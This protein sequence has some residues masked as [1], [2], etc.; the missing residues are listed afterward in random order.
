MSGYPYGN[1]GQYPPPQPQPQI[2]PQLYNPVNAAVPIP[3][4]PGFAQPFQ[5]QYQPTFGYPY[6]PGQGPPG[7]PQTALSYPSA[8][9]APGYAY[10]A[11]YGPVVEWISTTPTDAHALSERAIFGGYYYDGS[12]L[13]VIRARFE[14]D[15]VPGKL[16]I[17]HQAAFVPWGGKENSVK[18]IEVCCARVSPEWVRWQETREAN[19]PQNAI[20]AGSTSN[21][22]PLYVGRAREDG[23]LTPGKVHPSHKVL[24]IPHCVYE[25]V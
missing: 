16:A 11:P 8:P 18:K 15:L 13:W 17:K 1:P 20:I 5:P 14:G 24:Y 12:P 3:P 4:Q 6:Q 25:N 7:Q 9:S 19:I 21:G 2:Y 10:N 22:E 23:S